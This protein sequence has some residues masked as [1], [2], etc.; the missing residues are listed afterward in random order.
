VSKAEADAL[1]EAKASGWKVLSSKRPKVK[2]TAAPAPDRVESKASG[3]SGTA[4]PNL[5]AI[6]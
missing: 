2:S 3:I 1:E 6:P 5:D 4:G